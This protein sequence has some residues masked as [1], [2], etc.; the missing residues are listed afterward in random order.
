MSL[1][2]AGGVETLWVPETTGRI[3]E[4]IASTPTPNM[5]GYSLASDGC[6]VAQLPV[7]L[8]A[9]HGFVGD[10]RKM[11]GPIEK[12]RIGWV[13]FVRKSRDQV[14]VRACVDEGYEA[15]DAAWKLIQQRT[16][17][18]LSGAAVA[19]S[20]HLRGVVEGVRYFDEWT[21]EEVSVCRS[22]ANPDCAFWI[23]QR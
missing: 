8:L 4:G 12:C 22:G 9:S 19:R 11:A 23:P 5:H 1:E 7:P 15:A 13:V 2:R 14:L 18:A 6:R 3:I 10:S 17:R 16:L 21:L 20:T